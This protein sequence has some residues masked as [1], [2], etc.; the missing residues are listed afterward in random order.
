[1]ENDTYNTQNSKKTMPGFIIM[2]ITALIAFIF[3]VENEIQYPAHKELD[4]VILGL[5]IEVIEKGYPCL[6]K[7][8]RN[9]GKVSLCQLL[10]NILGHIYLPA[11]RKRNA[12][13]GG[14]G[15]DLRQNGTVI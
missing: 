7:L 11:F 3:A 9:I 2:A 6:D 15:F 13:L 10:L 12:V 5:I 14:K 4:I 8:V 1:M